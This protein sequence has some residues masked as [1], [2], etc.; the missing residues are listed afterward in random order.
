[1]WTLF[2]NVCIIF[3]IA[4]YG[5]KICLNWMVSLQVLPC[6]QLIFPSKTCFFKFYLN[7]QR[8]KWLIN[9]H[10]PRSEF[11]SYQMNSLNPAHQDL[12]INTKGTFQFLWNV[13]LQFNIIFSEKIIQYSKTFASQVQTP[14]NQANTPSSSRAFQRDQEHNL[15]HP[16]SVDLLST[17]KTKQ[18]NYLP[19]YIDMFFAKIWH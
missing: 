3:S 11:K 15:K 19:S 7:F 16:G 1:M 2:C 14:W 4:K 17:K 6:S 18:A 12:S 10:L 5:W 13:Q 8:L 9:Q